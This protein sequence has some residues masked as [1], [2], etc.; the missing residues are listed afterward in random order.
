MIFI[1]E[2]GGA[3]VDEANLRVEEDTALA[4]DAGVGGG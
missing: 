2:G 4:G 1:L 3:E